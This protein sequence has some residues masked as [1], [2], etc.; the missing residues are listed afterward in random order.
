MSRYDRMGLIWLL[1][2]E[3]VLDITETLAN[4]SGGLSF[5]RKLAA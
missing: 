2:G 1:R 3:T 4:L 5:Y